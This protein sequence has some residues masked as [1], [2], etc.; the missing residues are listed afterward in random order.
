[1]ISNEPIDWETIAKE[2]IWEAIA[3]EAIGLLR[4]VHDG[5]GLRGYDI[6]QD[7]ATFLATH[8]KGYK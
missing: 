3:K 8:G 5:Q 7:I 4:Q 2:A 6:H 1:M